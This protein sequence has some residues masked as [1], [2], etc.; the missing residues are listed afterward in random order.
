MFTV[1]TNTAWILF[2][3]G[4]AV[5]LAV[6][7]VLFRTGDISIGTV[8]LVFFYSTLL[9]RPLDRMT[10]HLDDLQKAGASIRR[11]T[12]LTELRSQ[13]HDG[14]GIPL[15]P[16]PLALAFDDV[17]FGYDDAETVIHNLSFS[18]TPGTVLGLLGRTG[19]GKI[20]ITRLLLR[21]YDPQHGAIC[22]GDAHGS[23][24]I[25]DARLADLRQR[26]GMVTQNVQ[27]FDATIRDNLTLF[28]RR[29]SDKQI[30]RVIDELGLQSW[31]ASLSG[32]L[33]TRL[34]GGGLSAGEAQ[35]LA[36]TRIFLKDPSMVILDE[37]SSRLDPATE[38]LVERAVRTL[39][40]GRTA[41]VIAHRLATVEHVDEIMILD[42]GRVLE[43]G[44]RAQLAADPHSRFAHLLRTGGIEEVLA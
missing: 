11:V 8:Y 38:H 30:M 40:K 13:I 17:S 36:F 1:M 42:G 28:D 18:I 12:Q 2:A 35:L 24:N 15:P 23:C 44:P 33:D 41:I 43:H 32:G 26:I 7:A 25:R 22:I 20:T 34:A 4:N 3:I 37:A 6:G 27:L 5:A 29:I 19:S 9:A 14:V 16:G 10:R 39:L 21:L 31:Y